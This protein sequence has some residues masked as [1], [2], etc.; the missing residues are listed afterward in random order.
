MLSK[1]HTLRKHSRRFGWLRT[2]QLV[3]AQPLEDAGLVRVGLILTLDLEGAAAARLASVGHG[4]AADGAGG[5]DDVEVRDLTQEEIQPLADRG[6]DWFFPAAVRTSLDRGD[7]CTAVLVNGEV[8]C[9]MW[10]TNRPIMQFGLNLAPP[11]PGFIGYRLFTRP[12]YRGRKL[13]ALLRAE[14]ARRGRA[15]GKR[16]WVNT[17]YCTNHASIHAAR[18][19]GF[20]RTGTI[21]VLGPDRRCTRWLLSNA[22]PRVAAVPVAA[23]G[24]PA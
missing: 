17:M 23:A 15:D 12:E 3:V 11:A 18:A 1:L 7:R 5:G 10:S 14:I 6:A 8:A 22:E 20:E 2:A 16:W 9:S 13:Q 4:G 19:L 21:V 24:R